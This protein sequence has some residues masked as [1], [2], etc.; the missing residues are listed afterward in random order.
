VDPRA[1]TSPTEDRDD[2]LISARGID[3]SSGMGTQNRMPLPIAERRMTFHQRS[4]LGGVVDAERR[5]VPAGAL[6]KPGSSSVPQPT[7]GTPKV[8]STSSVRPTSEDRLGARADHRDRLS[9]T[10]HPGRP[11][12]PGSPARPDARRR[13]HRSRRRGCQRAPPRS[14]WPIR[15]PPQPGRPSTPD[16]FC[17]DNLGQAGRPRE[18][19]QGDIVQTDRDPPSRVAMVAGTATRGP[20]RWPPSGARHRALAGY[21]RPWVMSVDSSAYTGA[22]AAIAAATSATGR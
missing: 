17:R 12:C 3:A 21:A 14:W 15:G 1:S 13:Y 6:K 16:R 5:T 22:P 8:S 19:L 9:G 20:D 10:A 2:G 11:R 7:T 4:R 18:L